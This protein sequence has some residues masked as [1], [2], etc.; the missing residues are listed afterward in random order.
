MNKLVDF[1]Y[2]CMLTSMVAVEKRS[3]VNA[4]FASLLFLSLC[5]TDIS[6]SRH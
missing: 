4:T 3:C 1:V 2:M 6:T 5:L